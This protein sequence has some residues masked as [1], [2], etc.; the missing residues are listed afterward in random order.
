MNIFYPKTSPWEVDFF[1]NDIF[2]TE[3]YN[4]EINFMMFDTNTE[5]NNN[6]EQHNIIV[7]N[8]GISLNFLENM[9]KKLKPFTIFHLG[10]ESGED[11]EY[12]D[13]YNRYNTKLLFHQFNFEKINYKMNHYQI[14]L[15]YVSGFVSNNS[16]INSEEREYNKTYD[17]S[18]VGAL[19]S[20]RQEMLNKFS[21]NFTKCCFFL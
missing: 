5:I 11:I 1:K 13:L 2:K 4:V 12:Y 9:I 17:F 19:K 20:D 8:R 10:D 16:S 7:I 18:F 14:P 15:G 6:D 3:L 21:N